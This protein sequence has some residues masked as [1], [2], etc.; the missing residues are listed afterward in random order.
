MRHAAASAL[1]EGCRTARRGLLA[2][3]ALGFPGLLESLSCESSK[4]PISRSENDDNAWH[5]PSLSLKGVEG[6][7][8]FAQKSVGWAVPTTTRRERWARPTLR[9]VFV[10]TFWANPPPGLRC[11][12]TLFA[13]VRAPATHVRRGRANPRAALSRLDARLR[14]SVAQAGGES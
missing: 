10:A 1:D 11:G 6:G 7:N 9:N 8:N 4:H 3:A 5:A 12:P 13:S 14:T 2:R